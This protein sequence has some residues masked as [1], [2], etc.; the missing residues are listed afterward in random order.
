[1]IINFTES[2]L[3]QGADVILAQ[4]VKYPA[5]VTWSPVRDHCKKL[6]WLLIQDMDFSGGSLTLFVTVKNVSVSF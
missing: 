5:S 4:A 1:M 6:D 3:F 2:L